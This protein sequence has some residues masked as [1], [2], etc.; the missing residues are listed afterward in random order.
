MRFAGSSDGEIDSAAA[1]IVFPGG[2]RP[3]RL[4]VPCLVLRGPAPE[5]RRGSSFTVELS[6][7]PELE[8]ALHGQ[9][10]TENDGRAPA[11]VALEK[12]GRVLAVSAGKPIWTQA[13]DGATETASALPAELGEREFLRDRLT[14]GRFWS[15]LPIVHFLKRI[16]S[17]GSEAPPVLPACFVIDNPTCGSRHTGTCASPSWRGT[18]GSAATTSR[19]RR[20]ARPGGTRAGGGEGVSGVAGAALARRARQRPRAPGAGARSR[21]GWCRDGDPLSRGSCGP[22]RG[23][24]RDPRRAGDVPAARRLRL[25]DA[26]GPLPVR[27][28][29]A[30]RVPAVPVGRVCRSSPLA[31]RWGRC[32]RSSRPAGFP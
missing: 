15:L 30:R 11:P 26:V 27:V 4:R 6:R 25:R 7:G 24:G 19:S 29:R 12:G 3:N 28:P 2:D 17:A 21:G 18:L 13:G 1:A 23:A 22:V 9:R 5:E 32:P 8:R 16:A 31:P 14:A 20:S 10:L